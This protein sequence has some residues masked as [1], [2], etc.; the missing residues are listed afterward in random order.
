MMDFKVF[1]V[2][3]W[4]MSERLHQRKLKMLKTCFY[5]W[6]FPFYYVRGASV[7]LRCTWQMIW[8]AIRLILMCLAAK[9]TE[10]A[11]FRRRCIFVCFRFRKFCRWNL[12][13]PTRWGV[14]QPWW[15]LTCIWVVLR[16]TSAELALF[17]LRGLSIHI[18]VNAL[19]AQRPPHHF[20]LCFLRNI[21]IV[22]TST[23]KALEKYILASPSALIEI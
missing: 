13:S 3:V 5:R 9:N 10:Q 22:R 18:L 2:T 1:K 21:P 16:Q 23:W 19:H 11:R 15:G 17:S 12:L 14:V 8:S 7:D 6:E 20:G 4:T